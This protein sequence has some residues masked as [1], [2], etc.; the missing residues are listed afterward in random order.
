MKTISASENHYLTQAR[1]DSEESRIF[2]R[3]ISG[4]ALNEADWR[5]ATPEEKAEWE[6][7]HAEP[8]IV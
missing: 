5:E 4:A 3:K 1:V 2:V 8:E 6:A 7:A